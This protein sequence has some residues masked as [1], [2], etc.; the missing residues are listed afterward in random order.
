MKNN[1]YVS[2]STD[3]IGDFQEMVEYAKEMQG[4]A[5]FLHCDIMDGVF[6]PKKNITSSHVFNINQNSLIALDVHLMCNEPYAILTNF[7]KAGANII[8]I[9]YEAFNNKND[10]VKAVKLIKEAHA[11]AGLAFN[12][13]TDVRDIKLF[14]HDFDVVLVMSVNPGASGQKFIPE[15][16]EKI[17]MLD[18]IR[19]ENSFNFKIE[20]D[21]GVNE[22]NAK[23]I[24]A[25]GADILV[26][27]SYVYKSNDRENAVEKLKK[28][29]KQ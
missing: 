9:H 26:S 17:K 27:G 25:S 3:P 22:E 16:L 29:N 23:E 28:S 21:G 24:V 14:L 8:T 20:V 19:K 4:K 10:I 6:V 12:P 15:T 1:V 2:L 7:I 18:E 13:E 5:D 11:L